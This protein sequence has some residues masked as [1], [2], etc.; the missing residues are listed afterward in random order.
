MSQSSLLKTERF[1]PLFI[2]QFLGA[3]NNNLFKNSLMVM[4][5]IGMLQSSL[6]SS[7]MLNLCAA[8]FILPFFIFSPLAGVLADETEKSQMLRKLKLIEIVMIV[9]AT[10]GIYTKNDIFLLSCVFFLGVQ[11][12]FFGPIKYSI[13]PQHLKENELT[14]G[15]GLIESATF[16]AIL[17]GTILGGSMITLEHGSFYVCSAL[18]IVAILGYISSLKIPLAPA[19]KNKNGLT[20]Q[21]KFTSSFKEVYRVSKEKK[22]IFLSILAISWFWFLGAGLLTQFPLIVKNILQKGVVQVDSH[23]ITVLLILFAIGIAIGSLICEKLSKSRIEIGLVPFGSFGILFSMIYFIGALQDCNH[24][25]NNKI[26]LNGVNLDFWLQQSSFIK[27][28]LSLLCLSIFSGF[29]TVPLY[30]FIQAKT[31]PEKRSM[32]IGANNLWNSI[33]MVS[34]AIFAILLNSLGF[35]L[36]DLLIGFAVLHFIISLYIFTVVPEFMMRFITWILISTIYRIDTKN[37][38]KLPEEG[39]GIIICNHVSFMD[40]L[41]IFG[42][43]PR[44]VKFVMYYKIFQIPFFKYMFK[45]VGAIPIASKKEDEQVFT[46]AFEKINQYLAEGE[47]VVIFPEGQI[48]YDGQLQE[49]K[50]GILKILKDHPVPVY[51][52]ALSGLYGSMFSRKDKGIFRYFPKAFFNHKV[53]FSVGEKIDEQ[54]LEKMKEAVSN[55]RENK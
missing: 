37:L 3:F 36:I 29:F 19:L 13:L 34:S 8:L 35:D 30:A 45:A 10:I 18:L 48:T 5:T 44:P 54:S 26:D 32:M 14:A 21:E 4:I 1:L 39:A 55:L 7:L 2:T 31:A 43:T 9:V 27:M 22:S 33:F 23:L 40:A 28:S 50:P 20:L 17:A 25:L 6:S 15:N 38:E 24:L 52:T 46:E 12:A 49:F 47:L 42:L 16:I 53:K 41:F 11:A 51:P